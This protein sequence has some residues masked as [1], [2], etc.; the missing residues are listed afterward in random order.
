MKPQLPP[1]PLIWFSII[2]VFVVALD[3]ATKWAVDT[4]LADQPPVVIVP[5]F[6]QLIFR[7]NTGAAFSMFRDRP[8][9]LAIFAA[10]IAV[11]ILVWSIRLRGPE[12]ALR[13]PLGLI[14]GGACGN[15]VDRVRLGHVV[16]FLDAYWRDHHWPTFNV[17]DSAIFIGM[18]LM[19]WLSFTMPEAHADEEGGV[20]DAA[21][22]DVDSTDADLGKKSGEKKSTA[23]S[24]ARS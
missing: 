2:V 3:Q 4:W 20:A 5:G 17:A 8:S 21:Q 6:F 14:L 11:F 23:D 7:T 19:I 24:Q 12:Q 15:L 16:D 9:V 1:L 18:G 13:W 10:C 22:S